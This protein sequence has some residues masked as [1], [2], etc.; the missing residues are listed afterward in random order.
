MGAF[1]LLGA[2][3]KVDA[4]LLNNATTNNVEQQYAP[5]V[6]SAGLVLESIFLCQVRPPVDLIMWS[7]GMGVL[8]ANDCNAFHWD[9]TH[10]LLLHYIERNLPA[11][12]AMRTYE[13]RFV[14]S[15]AIPTLPPSDCRSSFPSLLVCAGYVILCSE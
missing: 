13:R 14:Y 3:F 7:C 11:G 1:A 4:H 12:I 9:E 8:L 5:M 10:T 6:N 15:V 2:P